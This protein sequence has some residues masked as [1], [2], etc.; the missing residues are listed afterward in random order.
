MR[1]VVVSPRNR[2]IAISVS[3][4]IARKELVGPNDDAHK[5]SGYQI[6]FGR[7]YYWRSATST[8][9]VQITELVQIT[10]FVQMT[11]FVQITEVVQM[12]ELVQMTQSPVIRS[13]PARESSWR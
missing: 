12:T 4:V 13:P 11:E 3:S 6:L 8:S 5:S 2:T 7:K 9:F 1:V 10:E